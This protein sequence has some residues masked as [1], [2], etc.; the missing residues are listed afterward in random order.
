MRLILAE[1]T[2]DQELAVSPPMVVTD[3]KGQFQFIAVA[4]GMYAV[5]FAPG[6]WFQNAA[7]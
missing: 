1:V 2:G 6:I 4:P 5:L 7:G 3:D